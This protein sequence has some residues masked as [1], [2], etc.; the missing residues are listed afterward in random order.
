MKI[1]LPLLLMFS[2]A[3]SAQ[4]DE[5]ASEL[6]YSRDYNSALK[7]AKETNKLLMLV[8]VGDYCP[9]CKKFERKTLSS[10]N[11]KSKVSKELTP[12][13]IDNAK[14]RGNYPEEFYTQRIPT[15]LFIDPKTQKSIHK[16]LGYTKKKE[17]LKDIDSALNKYKK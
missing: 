15:V 2:L 8:I 5:F 7:D 1:L 12:L 6:N 10:K 17:F 13:I 11:I 4:I 16:T 3:F 9:W 14:D